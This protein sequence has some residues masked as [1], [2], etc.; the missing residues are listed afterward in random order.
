MDITM[1]VTLV[2]EIIDSFNVDI[3][4]EDI[5]PENFNSLEAIN[6]LIERKI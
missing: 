1:I 5:V 6:K 3:S 2:G 4:V